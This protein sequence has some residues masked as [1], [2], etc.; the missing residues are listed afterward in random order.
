MGARGGAD[1]AAADTLALA[2]GGTAAD[3]LGVEDGAGALVVGSSNPTLAAGIGVDSGSS[4][5][6]ATPLPRANAPSMAATSTT[7]DRR[8]GLAL[9]RN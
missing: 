1:E 4:E 3:V 5:D 6:K 2:G 9:W 8:G 7:R